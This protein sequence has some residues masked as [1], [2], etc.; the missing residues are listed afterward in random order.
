QHRL[1]YVE[2]LA[3]IERYEDVEKL[4]GRLEI[5]ALA[6]LQSEL[7]E[8][9]RVRRDRSASEVDWLKAMNALYR[10]LGMTPIQFATDPA[11]PLMDRLRAN[12]AQIYSGPKVSVIMPTYSPGKSIRTAIRSLLEQ[13]WKNIEVIVVDDASPD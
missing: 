9:Q 7:I 8:I 10:S 6:P 3:D 12:P 1:Q 11:L 2:A 13:S 4:R 5:N